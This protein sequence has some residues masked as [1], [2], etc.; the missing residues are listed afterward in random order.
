MGKKR[1]NELLGDLVIKPPGKPALVLETDKRPALAL[2]AAEEFQK[3]KPR[4]TQKVG[5]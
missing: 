3:I 4:K 5:K 1:F 2:S